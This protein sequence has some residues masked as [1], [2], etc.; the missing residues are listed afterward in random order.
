MGACLLKS[1]TDEL[2]CCGLCEHWSAPVPFRNQDDLGYCKIPRRI[3]PRYGEPVYVKGTKTRS[4]QVRAERKSMG[5]TNLMTEYG[6]GCSQF[7]LDKS[8]EFSQ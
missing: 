3:A 7:L 8:K 4:P 5:K 2:K 1:V 6:D